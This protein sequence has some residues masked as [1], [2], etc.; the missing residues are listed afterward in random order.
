MS[1]ASFRLGRPNLGCI[2]SQAD[3][4]DNAYSGE[5]HGRRHDKRR[6]VLNRPFSQVGIRSPPA[7]RLRGTMTKGNVAQQHAGAQDAPEGQVV[8][9]S[10][11]DD[12]DKGKVQPGAA[13][14]RVQKDRVWRKDD[15]VPGHAAEIGGRIQEDEKAAEHDGEKGLNREEDEAVGKRHGGRGRPGGSSRRGHCGW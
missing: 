10:Q 14:R 6:P 15:G 2:A 5:H 4:Q 3:A 7:D 13:Q 12:L 8:K 9:Q 11:D 1:K